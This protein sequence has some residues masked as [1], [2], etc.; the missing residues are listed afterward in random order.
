MFTLKLGNFACLWKCPDIPTRFIRLLVGLLVLVLASMLHFLLS[1]C[2]GV[3]LVLCRLVTF[4]SYLCLVS[5]SDFSLVLS[6]VLVIV[7]NPYS[8]CGVR[9]VV[10][11]TD[12]YS[13]PSVISI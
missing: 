2:S 4:G 6:H 1:Y 3:G 7:G 10:A 12:L 13:A 5:T 11:S 8:S 9:I